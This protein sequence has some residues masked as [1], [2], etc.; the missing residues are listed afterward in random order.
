MPQSNIQ[1]DR[2][3]SQPVFFRFKTRFYIA[4]LSLFAIFAAAAGFHLFQIASA[5]TF[6]KTA[7]DS[8]PFFR[9]GERLTYNIS[10]NKYDNAAYAEI[11][12]VSRGKLGERDAVELRGKI[13]TINLVSS[14]FYT[15]NEGRTT[16]ASPE[17]NLP[18]YIRKTEN[19]GILPKEIIYNYLVNPTA[20]NDLLTLIYQIRNANGV[21]NFTFQE[22]EKTYSI[23]LLN[24]A[25]PERVKTDA[26]DFETSVSTAQSQFFTDAGITNFRI[27]FTTDEA[28][29]PVLIRFKTAKGDFRAALASRS[30]IEPETPIEPTPTPILIPAPQKTPKPAATATPYIDNQ[31]LLAELPFALGETLEYQVSTV[32]GKYFGN[33]TLRAIERKL[34]ENQD[35][36][37]LNAAASLTQAGNPLFNLNDSIRAQVN[38][39]SLAPLQTELKS[40]GSFSPYNQIAKFDQKNGFVVFNGA[41]RAEVP[42]RT[43]SLLSLVY[44]I[45]SFNLKPSKDP[46]NPVNDTRVAVFVGTQAYVF[47]LRPFEADIITL[48]GEKVS[49]QLISI[50]T[51]NPAID[52]LNPR[53]WLGTDEKRLPLRLNIG[54]YQ[55]DLISE[56]NLTPR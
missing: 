2:L 36:L 6:V 4:F 13:K 1:T 24:G 22:A 23:S 37:L 49:A 50:S 55:A 9:V 38:P 28:R 46:K 7:P 44:A 48:K 14:I 42:I 15:L 5:Q 21:G 3:K 31:P 27:N 41:S 30:I 20:A 16:F 47:T 40:T 32:G 8:S 45:R 52:Q 39:D 12:A 19:T 34:F 11:Y 43:H 18:L 29:V 35:S 54:T 17:T 33:V 26:G 25:P 56:T 51:G 10:F 53:L